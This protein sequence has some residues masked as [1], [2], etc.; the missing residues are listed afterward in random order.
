MHLIPRLYDVTGGQVL[1]DDRDVRD[2]TLEELRE[3]IG[4]V[5]QKNTLFSGS[6][7]DNIRWG[8]EQASQEEIETACKDAPGA[9]LHHVV[10]EWV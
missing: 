4:V 10:P 2:Y 3:K 8:N 5:L 1:V 9:R 6:I 7:R